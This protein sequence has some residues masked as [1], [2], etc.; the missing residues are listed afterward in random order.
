MDN[1][2]KTISEESFQDEL[3]KLAD[4]YDD[5]YANSPEEETEE[6]Y[7]VGPSN[8]EMSYDSQ[9]PN[10]T[11]PMLA[12]IG[13]GSALMSGLGAL[14]NRFAG[15]PVGSNLIR[16]AIIGGLIGTASAGIPLLVKHFTQQNEP[17]EDI[18]AEPINSLIEE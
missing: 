16:N 2:F 8:Q 12:G 11:A 6:E 9:R 15:N 14:R 7:E 13:S 5:L 18:V 17:E 1:Q 10:I 4:Y 3:K